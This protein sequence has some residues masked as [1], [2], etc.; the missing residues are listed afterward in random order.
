MKIIWA[1]DAFENNFE[2]IEKMAHFINSI[3]LET[4]SQI[5]PLYL[6]LE[7]EPLIPAQG[8]NSW[9]KDHARTAESLFKEILSDLELPFTSNAKVIPHNS[10]SP[11]GI[12]ESLHHYALR[13]KS[14]LIFIGCHARKGLSRALLGSVSE[15]LLNISEIPVCIIN[16]Q[17]AR[18]AV[19]KKILFP[20][21][22]GDHS[23]ENFR[24]VLTFAKNM[25]AEVLL[26]HALDKP[27]DSFMGISTHERVF[28]V[29]G[30]L[31]TVEEISQAR[32]N[33]ASLTAGRWGEIA[34]KQ[35]VKYNYLIDESL[36]G[37][38]DSLVNA[39]RI[40][41][42]DL[43]TM[44]AQS[45]PMSGSILG[46]TTRKVVRSSSC[47]VYVIPRHFYDKTEDRFKETPAP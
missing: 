29:N 15:S 20:T 17:A 36:R 16:T 7:S 1:V 18:A 12:A 34:K 11:F 10:Q 9:Q 14:D 32:A 47:P 21:D 8:D 19:P 35:R 24:H 22:F 40:H 4:N 44:E 27:I 46:S 2:L 30:K 33:R 5:E 26:F 42:V 39:I 28:K 38:E 45:G 13:T 23:L 43:I 25:N 6:L 3:Y 37:L 31:M 41:G